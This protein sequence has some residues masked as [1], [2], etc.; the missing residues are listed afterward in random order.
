MF[1]SWMP[2]CRGWTDWL[3]TGRK[4]S[5]TMYLA[6]DYYLETHATLTPNNKNAKFQLA[7][8]Q[9]IWTDIPPKIYMVYIGNK[10]MERW[11]TALAARKNA[12]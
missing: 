9:K 4:D 11:S 7:Y 8:E 5:Q 6:T 12:N 2:L 1:C 10:H 3:Q